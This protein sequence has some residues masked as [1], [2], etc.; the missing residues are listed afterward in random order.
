M[1][2]PRPGRPVPQGTG[3]AVRAVHVAGLLEAATG[4]LL[5]AAT[6]PAWAAGHDAVVPPLALRP[7][8]AAVIGLIFML[9][10]TGLAVANPLTDP[11]QTTTTTTTTTMNRTVASPRA[12]SRRPPGST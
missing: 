12:T 3:R 8:D 4:L 9:C 7:S 2:Q 6:T 1:P 11:D 5:L 10:G